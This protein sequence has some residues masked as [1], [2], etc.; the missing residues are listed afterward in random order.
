MNRDNFS[1]VLMTDIHDSQK[2]MPLMIDGR[3]IDAWI[4]KL[5]KAYIIELMNPCDD[6]AMA[7][8]TT[9]E[10]IGNPKLNSDYVPE[11]PEKVEYTL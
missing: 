4:D 11:T 5:P 3:N 10:V 9:S 7:A 8:H 6:S 1:T 2:R